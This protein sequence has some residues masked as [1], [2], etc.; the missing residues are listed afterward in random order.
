M[1]MFDWYK[2]AGSIACP[3]CGT[4]LQEWQGKDANNLLL[5]WQEGSKHPI[6][7]DWDD[8]DVLLPAEDYDHYTL[9]AHFLIYSHDC[10]THQPI[11]AYCS[12]DDE[13]VWT[14]TW[15]IPYNMGSHTLRGQSYTKWFEKIG[16]A[17][18][19]QE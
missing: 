12:T 1:G 4:P 6:G 15:V 8:P 14:R 9:P 7:D 11:E 17:A 2:P 3:E 19:H 13:G 5:I 10:P 18:T 16:K